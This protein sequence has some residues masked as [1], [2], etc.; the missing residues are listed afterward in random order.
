MILTVYYL[1]W[2]G[3]RPT[4]NDVAITYRTARYSPTA[5][6]GS[7]PSRTEHPP[8]P[9]LFSLE[10]D[11][12]EEDKAGEWPWRRPG[13]AWPGSGLPSG[14]QAAPQPAASRRPGGSG[15]APAALPSSLSPSL[16]ALPVPWVSAP[17]TAPALSPA[18]GTAAP[19][20][21]LR[22]RCS[23]SPHSSAWPQHR[24]R[25]APLGA[26]VGCTLRGA[27]EGGTRWFGAGRRPWSGQRLHCT[28]DALA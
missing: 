1:L 3:K 26:L 13:P 14:G 15:R 18:R 24:D 19:G 22:P 27:H 25:A 9:T 28:V 17:G 4:C 16:P 20:P 8:H 6:N 23:S 5:G 10:S 21:A 12:F 7:Q 2:E 11:E